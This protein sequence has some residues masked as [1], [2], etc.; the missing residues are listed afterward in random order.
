MRVPATLLFLAVVLFATGCATIQRGN[1]TEQLPVVIETSIADDVHGRLTTLFP[2]AQTT[3]IIRQEIKDTDKFGK[4]LIASLRE[5][6]YG[7]HEVENRTPSMGLPLSYIV[8]HTDAMVRVTIHVANESLTRAYLTTNGTAQP[9]A[10]WARKEET[11][12]Q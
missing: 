3:F 8:D 1:F 2:P 9:A 12:A 7:V 11:H 4:R 5:S 10:V 6:G